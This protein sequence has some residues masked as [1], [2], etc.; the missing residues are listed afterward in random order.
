M[1]QLKSCMLLLN[2]AVV[3]LVVAAVD[4]ANA[5]SRNMQQQRRPH[6]LKYASNYSL[7][8]FIVPPDCK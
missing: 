2:V 4:A 8:E 5:I 1:R 3:A 7:A 6:A